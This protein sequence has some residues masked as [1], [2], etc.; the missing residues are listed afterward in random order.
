MRELFLWK[1]HARKCINRETRHYTCSTTRIQMI[2]NHGLR[3]SASPVLTATGFVNGIGQISTP[4]RIHTLWPIT[5]QFV[6]NDY[7]GDSY[8]CATFGA[9]PS[10]GSFW[11][12][13]WKYKKNNFIYL[14]I[15]TFFSGTNLQVRPV[16]GFSRSMAQTTRTRARVC[17][18]GFRWYCSPFWEWNPPKPQFLGVGKRFQ[19]KREKYWNFHIIEITLSI[20]IKFCEM[21]ET[22]KYSSRI[23]RIRTPQQIQD[24]RRPPFWKNC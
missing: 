17:L 11:A 1:K 22:T 14:F 13:G 15:Y 12:N 7:V 6:A 24:G 23:V 4:H 19:A 16:D 21:I 8:G 9:N 20:S 3:G 5:K 10:T 2:V 18:L